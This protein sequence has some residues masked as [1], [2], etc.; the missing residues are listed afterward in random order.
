MVVKMQTVCIH[1]DRNTNTQVLFDMN[2]NVFGNIHDGL[3]NIK[4]LFR[5]FGIILLARVLRKTV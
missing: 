1:Y 3:N 4:Y 5:L 2:I